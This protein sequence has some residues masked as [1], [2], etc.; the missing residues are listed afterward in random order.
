MRK[1]ISMILVSVFVFVGCATNPVINGKNVGGLVG[2]SGGAYGGSALFKNCK[3][4]A[5]VA[6]FGGS[7]PSSGNF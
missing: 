7:S 6:K 4:V 2:D 5:K 1:T 3:G